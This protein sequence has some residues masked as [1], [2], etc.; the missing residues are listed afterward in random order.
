ML[1]EGSQ[2]GAHLRLVCRDEFRL[3]ALNNL[4]ISKVRD[5]ESPA[6]FFCILSKCD[7]RV[8]PSAPAPST[9]RIPSWTIACGCSKSAPPSTTLWLVQRNRACT[10]VQLSQGLLY[11]SKPSMPTAAALKKVVPS[12]RS[13]P[14]QPSPRCRR[15]EANV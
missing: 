6:Y 5:A 11:R 9:T 13:P 3:G 7:R 1:E 8:H 2:V 14:V 10:G 15:G 12:R 4:C